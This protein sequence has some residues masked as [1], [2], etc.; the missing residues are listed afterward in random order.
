MPTTSSESLNRLLE[1]FNSTSRVIDDLAKGFSKMLS[2]LN[3]RLKDIEAKYS[4]FDIYLKKVDSNLK[5]NLEKINDEHKNLENKSEQREMEIQKSIKS[6]TEKQKQILSTQSSLE[7]SIQQLDQKFNAL[8]IMMEKRMLEITD[9][10]ANIIAPVENWNKEMS[11][12][13]AE[14][15]RLSREIE[16]RFLGDK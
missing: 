10:I 14:V 9:N 11:I 4:E 12:I 3:N 15:D 16:K 5:N 2:E 8:S 1:H 6:L 7:I 13:K